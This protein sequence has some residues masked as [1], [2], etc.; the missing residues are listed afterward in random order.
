MDEQKGIEA[1]IFLQSLAG[2][3]ESEE[4]ARKGWRSLTDMQKRS[5]MQTYSMMKAMTVEAE[6]V[7]GGS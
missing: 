2:I 3:E 6:L 7:D 4:D 5:T 1:I